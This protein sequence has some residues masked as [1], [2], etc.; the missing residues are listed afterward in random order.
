MINVDE[1]IVN[2][3]L[4]SIYQ[5]LLRLQDLVNAKGKTKKIF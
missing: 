2:H 5:L 4:R 3:L 1:T